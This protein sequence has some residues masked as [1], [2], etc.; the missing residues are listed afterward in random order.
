MLQERYRSEN[1]GIDKEGEGG[2][3][4]GL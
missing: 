3:G 2:G 1:N 4:W